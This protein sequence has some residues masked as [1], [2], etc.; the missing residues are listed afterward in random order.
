LRYLGEAEFNVMVADTAF[1]PEVRAVLDAIAPNLIEK[2]QYMDFLRN[3]TFR[4]TLVCPA[5]IQP[6]YDVSAAKLRGLHVASSLQPSA[7]GT[8]LHGDTSAEF[9]TSGGLS[10]ATSD[11]IV[12]A[13]LSVLGEI[14]PQA[15]PFDKL[16]MS[17]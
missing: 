1:P 17:A 5:G 12:K 7:A 14:W 9:K 15:L 4:Q 2:E 8:D 6:K 3:R 16:R 10:L 13:A 11:P